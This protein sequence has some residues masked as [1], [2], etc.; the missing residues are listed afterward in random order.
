MQFQKAIGAELTKSDLVPA[1]QNLLK[2]VEAEV[3]SASATKLKEF[4]GS[5]PPDQ[6]EQLVMQY[7]LP[8]VKELVADSNTHVKTALAAVIMGLAPLIGKDKYFCFPSFPP[9]FL[10]K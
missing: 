1:F 4:C 2:D 6:R 10:T 7:V 8:S 5:L 3:R 9:C